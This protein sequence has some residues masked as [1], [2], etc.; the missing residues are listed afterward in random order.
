MTQYFKATGLGA[1]QTKIVAKLDAGTLTRLFQGPFRIYTTGVALPKCCALRF[2]VS[3][4]GADP[5]LALRIDYGPNQFQGLPL[6]V[7]SKGADSFWLQGT[8]ANGSSLFA[9]AL[10]PGEMAGAAKKTCARI[11]L[12]VY[13]QGSTA[14]QPKDF[15][16]VADS[17][18]AGPTVAPCPRMDLPP[19]AAMV[20][21]EE[22]MAGVTQDEDEEGE[23]YHED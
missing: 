2:Y 23:G 17:P 18:A 10:P 12:L 15:N 4:A 5:N 11:W 13:P 16:Y 3:P 21:Q 1:G 14:A 8:L 19:L 6:T 9:F 22:T 7:G 20:G